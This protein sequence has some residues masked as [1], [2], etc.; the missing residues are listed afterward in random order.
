MLSLYASVFVFPHQPS[1]RELLNIKAPQPLLH[2][3]YIEI[4]SL[5]F[6]SFFMVVAVMVQISDRLPALYFLI[7]E[8]KFINRKCENYFLFS[9]I[10]EGP[11]DIIG[12]LF[13]KY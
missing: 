4:F 12:Y 9:H 10:G 3:S 1:S 11:Y 7:W 13:I 2:S 8:V 5:H 6:L